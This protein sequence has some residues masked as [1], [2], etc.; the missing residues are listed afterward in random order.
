[1]TLTLAA[2]C[3]AG[4]HPPGTP[5]SMPTVT[6]S[7]SATGFAPDLSASMSSPGGAVPATGTI[8]TPSAI[9]TDASGDLLIGDYRSCR[10]LTLLDAALITVAGTGECGY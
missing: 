8:V 5:R 4:T 3:S 1:M 2:A 6:D 7:A 10:V 9:A